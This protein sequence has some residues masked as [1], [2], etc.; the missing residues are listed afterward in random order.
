MRKGYSVFQQKNG[1]YS[2][3][4]RDVTGDRRVEK[5]ISTHKAA[6]SI[7]VRRAS[8]TEAVNRGILKAEDVL[9]ERHGNLTPISA[10]LEAHRQSHRNKEVT[11]LHR[12]QTH[13]RLERVFEMGGIDRL[14]QCTQESVE[15]AIKAYRDASNLSA[16]TANAVIGATMGF[17]RWCVET[18][19]LSKMPVHRLR[20]YRKGLDSVE[21]VAWTEKMVNSLIDGLKRCNTRPPKSKNGIGL[22]PPDREWVYRLAWMTGLRRGEVFSLTRDSFRLEGDKPVLFVAA[23]DSKHRERD[24]VP[25]PLSILPALREFVM[26]K[27]GKLFTKINPKSFEKMFRGDCKRAGISVGVQ[28]EGDDKGK[29]VVFHGLRHGRITAWANSVPNLALV[30]KLARH[31]NIQT[32][33]RYVHTNTDDLHL[34]ANGQYRLTTMGA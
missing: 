7:G 12:E 21:R 22:P 23:A 3:A 25:I 13:N 11:G 9:R 31:K 17:F 2:V 18:G 6:T 14:S 30:Q 33:M 10:H 26:K 19:K 1:R 20:R 8:D 34:A 28:A 29:A 4:Y 27:Q 16:T 15:G 24:E 32:T 5:G